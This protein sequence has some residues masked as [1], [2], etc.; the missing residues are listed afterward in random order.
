MTKSPKTPTVYAQCVRDTDVTP[1]PNVYRRPGTSR[2]QFALQAPRDLAH[3]FKTQWACRVSLGTSELREANTKAKELHAEWERKF[4][5]MRRLDNPVQQPTVAEQLAAL[6]VT[7]MTPQLIQE[8]AELLHSRMLESDE[9]ARLAGLSPAD[10]LNQEIALEVEEGVLKRAYA[11]GDP[12]PVEN[13]LPQWMAAVGLQVADSDP[14]RPA[15]ARELVKARLKAI[16]ARR[17]RH[18]G[19][20]VDTPAEPRMVA[21]KGLQDTAAASLPPGEKPG[22]LLK[23]RDL[24]ELWK[25]KGQKPSAKS[26]ET[27]TRIVTMFEEVL[28]DPFL[29]SL[30]RSQGLKLRDHMLSTGM[31]PKTA[32]DRMGWV[33]TLFRYEM[34]ERQR[35]AS[36]P[37]ATI[38]VEGSGEAVTRRLP[39][40]EQMLRDLFHQP[41]FTGYELP[42]RKNAGRDAAYWV[43]IL[44]YYTGA[45]LTELVQLLTDD[46]H[47]E[48]GLW[49]LEFT[50]RESWQSLKNSPSFRKI[51]LH[52]ELLRLGFVEYVQA[53]KA[54]GHRRVFPMSPVSEVNNAGGALSSWFSTVKEAAGWGPARTFHSFRH[55]VETILKKARENPFHI[56]AYT[57]HSQGGGDADT[58]YTHLEPKDLLE[59]AE[60]IT[61]IGFELPRVWP[62]VGWQAPPPGALV[63]TKKRGPRRSKVPE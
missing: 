33:S 10:Y 35:L 34:K 8:A 36:D 17:E 3:H 6:P 21:L 57:G 56:N 51:P 30:T 49:C 43:P 31:S 5:A 22:H 16:R 46:V 52:P 61:A 40:T 53:M 15:L 44:G 28:G 27:A 26:I 54:A 55:H 2:W 32:A 9:A 41:L 60:K 20:L 58:T 23:L 59:T 11:T 4:A 37:W 14:L 63:E 42:T 18:S 48:G 50:A 62:P 39:P 25:N 29:V 24:L 38:Q 7:P 19:E 13:L 12:G 45:R 1:F 47:Q